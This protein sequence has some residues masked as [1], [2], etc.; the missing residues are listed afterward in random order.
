MK[1]VFRV[2]NFTK[3]CRQATE[4]L[5]KY[6]QIS[7]LITRIFFIVLRSG[8]YQTERH[9]ND[10]FYFAMRSKYFSLKIIIYWLQVSQILISHILQ[11]FLSKSVRLVFRCT[12]LTRR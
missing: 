2:S 8:G 11:I 12:A 10:L 9:L 6:A 5:T 4:F 3:R 1:V 7:A